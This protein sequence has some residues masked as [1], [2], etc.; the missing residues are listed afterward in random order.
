[1]IK[2]S[3][4]ELCKAGIQV[5]SMENTIWEER[6][7]VKITPTPNYTPFKITFN[8]PKHASFTVPWV[9]TRSFSK[10]IPVHLK[11]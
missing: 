9:E 2:T 7:E 8:A 4:P 5:L 11:N 1:M 6:G 3:F 10:G